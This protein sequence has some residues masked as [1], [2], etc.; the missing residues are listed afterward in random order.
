MTV[1][2]KRDVEAKNLFVITY[3]QTMT[4]YSLGDELC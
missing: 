3:S 1:Y 2:S 4:V